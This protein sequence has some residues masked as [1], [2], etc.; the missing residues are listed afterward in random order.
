MGGEEFAVFLPGANLVAA[1]LFAEGVRAA[2]ANMSF[3]GVPETARFTASFGVAECDGEESLSDLRRRA[4]TALY[5]AKRQGRD[6][7]RVADANLDAMPRH[8]LV[9]EAPKRRPA[10]SL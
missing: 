10:R 3:D 9:A 6:R 5:A 2:F 1:R 4:D 7:V 8:P